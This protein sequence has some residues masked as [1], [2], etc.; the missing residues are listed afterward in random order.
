MSTL[1][2]GQL[3]ERTG[4]S[5]SALRYYEGIGLVPPASRTDAGYRL[6]DEG[7]VG[8][9]AFIAR[10]K[11]LGCSLEEITDLASI[12]DGDR[13]APVQRRFH[14][15]ITAKIAETEQRLAELTRL[16][17]QLRSAAAQLSGDAVDG[18]C[19][20]DCACVSVPARGA[21]AAVALGRESGTL[22][23]IPIACTLTGDE[24]RD[25][26]QG[27]HDLLRH[28]SARS[29]AADGALRL[30][31]EASTPLPELARLIAAEQ[32][33]CAFFAFTLTIDAHG[34]TLDV[35]APDGAEPIVTRL[36]GEVA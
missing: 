6:Y 5:T 11:Q 4:F 26:E 33:C 19:G 20:D 31:F 13:C 29:E 34:T 16:A 32:G 17:D 1:T 10:A 23:D 35:R 36:F 9:M 14:D 2:I 25:R 7:T 3:A 27:W 28:V 30:T 24:A 22:D 18:P 21:T 8:R 15:L 12:W